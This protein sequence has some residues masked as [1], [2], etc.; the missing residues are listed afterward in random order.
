MDLL[1]EYEA[2]HIKV[3]GG[4]GGVIVPEE[5]RELEAYGVSRIY[6]PEDG[7][8]YGLQGIINDFIERCDFSTWDGDLDGNLAR[9]ETR[10]WKSIARAITAVEIA[11]ESG[12][13]DLPFIRAQLEQKIGDRRIPVLGITG[14]GGAGKSSLTD[15]IVLRF[16]N[17]QKDKTIGIISVDPTRRKSG[18]AL[19]G[20][21]IRMNSIHDPR[22]YYRSMATRGYGKEIPPHLEDAISVLKA[23]G[24]DFIIVETAGIGQ[25]D[26]AVV[27]LA[28]VNLYVMTREFGAQSQLEKID[29]LDFADVVAVNK[30][31]QKGSEDAIHDVRKQIQRNRV[32]FNKRTEEFPVYGTIASRFNDDGVTT[33][34]AGLLEAI[35]DED[36]NKLVHRYAGKARQKAVFQNNHYSTAKISISLRNSGHYPS[37]PHMGS[38]TGTAGPQNMAAGC[39]CQGPTRRWTC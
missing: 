31:D 14:P 7:R 20:D 15:E 38:R 10:D 37:V 3:F 6:S 33:L 29:M 18:G 1:R 21:R 13:G 30:Y 23:A 2:E 27:P 34:Y 28:D 35:N 17:D 5:I 4:G 36:R 19:L 22:V 24:F 26:A 9:L 11:T 32:E 8:K 12:D 25:G 39:R 16:L